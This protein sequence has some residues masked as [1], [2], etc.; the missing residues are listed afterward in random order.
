MTSAPS[1]GAVWFLYKLFS[2]LGI[3]YYFAGEKEGEGRKEGRKEGGR[4]R[5]RFL[6]AFRGVR[7]PSGASDGRDEGRDQPASLIVYV[8]W[9]NDLRSWPR[10]WW[11]WFLPSLNQS[12]CKF[13]SAGIEGEKRNEG[14]VIRPA[15]SQLFDMFRFSIFNFRSWC[16]DFSRCA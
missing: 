13:R 15:K 8:M 16:Y 2:D 14:G 1:A 4:G 12:H 11:C 6:S 7:D 5:V 9:K 3:Y 10:P